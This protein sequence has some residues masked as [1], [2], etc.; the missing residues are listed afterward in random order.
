MNTKE[1]EEQQRRWK[2]RKGES[3]QS[4]MQPGENIDW[5]R[6]RILL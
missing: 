4:K 5:G 2:N 6:D 1:R 3:V